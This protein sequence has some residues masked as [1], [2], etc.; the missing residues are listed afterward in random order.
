LS[1]ILI[2]EETSLDSAASSDSAVAAGTVSHDDGVELKPS[3]ET[4]TANTTPKS[5]DRVSSPR[6]VMRIANMLKQLLEEVQST[7]L[8]QPARE[9]LAEVYSASVKELVTHL[10]PD[11]QDE[12]RSLKLPLEED[13]DGTALTSRI[14]NADGV[15]RIALAQLVGWLEGLMAG[16]Q[17]ALGTQNPAGIPGILAAVLPGNAAQAMASSMTKPKALS[18]SDNPDNPDTQPGQYL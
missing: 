1:I 3:E 8:D 16:I 10:S 12:L 4:D 14:S 15:L 2:V 17:S 7:S 9:M 18:N 13:V 6:K 11:L 5:G